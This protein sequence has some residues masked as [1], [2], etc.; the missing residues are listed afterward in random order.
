MDSS[1][2]YVSSNLKTWVKILSIIV[3]ILLVTLFI[4]NT[5][6]FNKVDDNKDKVDDVITLN[7]TSMYTLSIFM[8]VVAFVA[9]G[10]FVINFFFFSSYKNYIG[11]YNNYLGGDVTDSNLDNIRINDLQNQLKSVI[12]SQNSYANTNDL[13]SK[14]LAKGNKNLINDYET[15]QYEKDRYEKGLSSCVNFIKQNGKIGEFRKQIGN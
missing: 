9:L 15:C 6:Y 2:S 5:V 12:E 4:F 14:Y 1:N 13:Y 3:L 10:V 8:T 7:G 11:Q